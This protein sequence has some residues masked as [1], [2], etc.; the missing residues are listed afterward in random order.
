MAGYIQFYNKNG[1]EYG[2]L[3]VSIWDKE[4]RTCTKTTEYLGRVIDKEK[5][6]FKSRKHGVFC[7][8]VKTNT[9]M[10]PPKD[11]VI[12][13]LSYKPRGIS[14]TYAEYSAKQKEDR[15]VVNSFPKVVSFG[16]EYVYE[17]LI[18]DYLGDAIC[19]MNGIE[20][21]SLKALVMYYSLSAEANSEALDW[22]QQSYAQVIYPEAKLNGAKISELLKTLGNDIYRNTFI[23]YFVATLKNKFNLNMRCIAI[24]STGIP[25]NAKL[26]YTA[27]SNHNGEFSNEARLIFVV[28][29][30]SCLP[31]YY[32]CCPGNVPD[33]KTLE[34]TFNHLK[35]LD[36]TP[37]YV[38]LDAAYSYKEN[39]DIYSEFKVDFLTRIPA[40]IKLYK[41]LI[42][43][44][45]EDMLKHPENYVAYQNRVLCIK[46]VPAQ[47]EGNETVVDGFAYICLDLERQSIEMAAANRKYMAGDINEQ[48]LLTSRQ[49]AGL[50][51]LGGTR[52]DLSERDLLPA[53]YA[54]QD[55]E[56]TFDIG[57]HDASMLPIN[58]QSDD[59]FLGHMLVSYMSTIVQK[60]FQQNIAKNFKYSAPSLRRKLRAHKAWLNEKN[61]VL[62]DI[63]GAPVEIYKMLGL[64][65]CQSLNYPESKQPK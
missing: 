59:A 48:E 27:I 46:R 39:I 22:Y 18:N 20:S 36:L 50:F 49:K 43:D 30:E 23:T 45:Y 4:K 6:I 60:V 38:V 51:M 53:Y 33:M 2:D 65:H 64:K 13:K 29:Q 5:L 11:L 3:R 32:R 8:D 25:N 52:D 40:S 55:I 9:K 62:S 37:E 12:P 31:L 35:A 34:A 16:E 44:N 14:K 10:S 57:K 7:L 15:R 58:I 26:S 61:I 42:H 54:K 21:D 56:Q 1:I 41:E 63:A 24:D 19:Q 28:D 47:L 17:K